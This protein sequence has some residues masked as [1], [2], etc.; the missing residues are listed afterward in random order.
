[1]FD[2]GCDDEISRVE[3]D[4]EMKSFRK[5]EGREVEED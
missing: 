4:G 2:D 3:A 5:G 1:M